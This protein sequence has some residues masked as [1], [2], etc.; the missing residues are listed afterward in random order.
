MAITVVKRDGA[1]V[2]YDR[3]KIFCTQSFPD[4]DWRCSRKDDPR[5]DCGNPQL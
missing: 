5:F 4:A 3:E 2:V 1:E